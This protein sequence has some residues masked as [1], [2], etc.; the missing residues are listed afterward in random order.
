[1]RLYLFN[2]FVKVNEAAGYGK[3]PFFFAKDGEVC[4]YF[5][6]VENGEDHR[7]FV[8]SVGKFSQFTQPSE[9]K[10][11]YGVLSITELT[12]DE[13]DQAVTDE[14][15]F[16][17]NKKQVDVDDRTLSEMMRT[18]SKIVAD[19][20]DNNAK[21]NKFYDEMQSKITNKTYVDAIKTSA[22][23]WPGEWNF[24][25]VERGKL[26]LISK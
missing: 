3:E 13:L 16:D 23:G 4:N 5:F 21:V 7:G 9:P 17:V 22:A 20:L 2:Q 11:D 19:Y 18:I 14:G 1:M 25:E 12:E 24:Q 15:K 6:K 26:N 10:S 8:V